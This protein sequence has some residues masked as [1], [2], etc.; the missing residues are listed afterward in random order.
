MPGSRKAD[1]YDRE[2]GLRVRTLR[3]S[4]RMPQSD[5]GDRHLENLGDALQASGAD[6]V[7]TVFVFLNLLEG[8][9]ELFAHVVLRH[10]AG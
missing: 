7:C 9:A 2:V 10:A 1:A 8:D 4:R 6:T 3:I 5:L